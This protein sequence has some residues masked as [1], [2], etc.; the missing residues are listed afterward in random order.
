MTDKTPNQIQICR[1]LD[2]I[3]HN[4]IHNPPKLEIEP[5]PELK[6]NE[7]GRKKDKSALKEKWKPWKRYK[8][9]VWKLTEK[10]PLNTL[11]G[12]ELRGQYYHLDHKISI[13]D[14]FKNNYPASFIANINNLRIISKNDNFRKNIQSYYDD[15]NRQLQLI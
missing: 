8:A 5:S 11:K 9:E 4:T 7:Y 6:Q 13:W 12:I 1:R 2:Y 3:F 14:G 15:K 10:Q